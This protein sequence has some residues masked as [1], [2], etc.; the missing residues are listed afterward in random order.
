MLR[1]ARHFGLSAAQLGLLLVTVATA[2]PAAAHGACDR[3]ISPDAAKQLHDTFS[4]LG[5]TDA[6]VWQG[7]DTQETQATAHWRK[8]GQLLSPAT[9]APHGCLP[10]ATL[11]GTT[12]DAQLP[13]DLVRAC[14]G[15]Q[16]G[17]PRA[18]ESVHRPLPVARD[19]EGGFFER[20]KPPTHGIILAFA[21][22]WLLALLA[23]FLLLRS[24]LRNDPPQRR[25]LFQLAGV[26]ALALA[27]RLAV[28]PSLANWYLEVV[29][30]SGIG[31]TRF[32]PGA[33][34]LQR[35]LFAV[36]PGS[37]ATLFA[38]SAL[39]GAAAIPLAMGVARILGLAELGVLAAGVLL[40]L[41]PLH[42]R[43]SVSGAAHV[44]ASTAQLAALLLW[45]S[46]LRR[47]NRWHLATSGLLAFLALAT[48]V[49][50]FAQLPFI[51]ACGWLFAAPQPEVQR[52]LRRATAAWLLVWLLTGALVWL[53]VVRPS[54]HP[55]PATDEIVRAAK[56]LLSQFLAAVSQH[57]QWL[58]ALPVVLAAVG[59][60]WAT[61][62]DRRLLA[63]TVLLLVCTFVP[64]G[65]TLE[66]EGLVGGRYFC[67]AIAWICLL[68]G[69]GVAWLTARIASPR[70]R[71]TVL[72]VTAVAAALSAL[73]ALQARY[74]FQDEYDFLRAATATLP[75][76]CTVVQLPVRDRSYAG[77]FDGTI[78][79]PRS[80]LTLVR[81]DLD[82]QYL[83]LGARLPV[84]PTRCLAYYQSALCEIRD[85]REVRE[86]FGRS[87]ETARRACSEAVQG[88]S[89][90]RLR[91]ATL[92]PEST[93]N[94][95]DG[96]A[97]T[98]WLGRVGDSN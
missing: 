17:F 78:D 23:A 85:S 89:I 90:R 77:D 48:R 96:Q 66:R 76:G 53:A 26:T 62:R 10:D 18:L 82:W 38:A 70:T 13:A 11:R 81:P 9:V 24:W 44:W 30:P 37:D 84:H 67:F 57:P 34:G 27:V 2:L 19:P 61:L 93:R 87:A 3:G 51:V 58:P 60:L 33:L 47:P 68:G 36:L 22:L 28:P 45:L 91:S 29:A 16:A 59:L 55:P 41:L 14:P 79:G 75:A 72:A 98:V 40:A 56:H 69:A 5:A 73:P 42:V 1:F 6:C 65:R 35:L 8:N 83:K 43:V 92:S 71:W 32:G 97:P 74:T 54:H 52:L 15:I 94:L 63:L 25:W 12:L 88:T 4:L 95:F 50:V 39:A 49:D 7:L 21:G 46:G 20:S 86:H 31:D 80:P 64:L